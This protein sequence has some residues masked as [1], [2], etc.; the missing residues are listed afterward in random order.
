MPLA[1]PDTTDATAGSTM[2]RALA[3]EAF[4][5]T[6]TDLYVPKRK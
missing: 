5:G 3:A 2:L 1:R 6:L 4:E